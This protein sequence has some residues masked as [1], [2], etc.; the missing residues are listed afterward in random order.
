[1]SHSVPTNRESSGV[2][3]RILDGMNPPLNQ[4]KFQNIWRML[5]LMKRVCYFW[6]CANVVGLDLSSG[7]SGAEGCGFDP[8]LAHQ[9]PLSAPLRATARRAVFRTSRKPSS[10]TGNERAR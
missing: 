8:R 6:P 4:N 7:R 5:V 3:G 9:P 2:N 1:M 10:D